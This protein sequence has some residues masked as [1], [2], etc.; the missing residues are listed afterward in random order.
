LSTPPFNGAKDYEKENA[1]AP[2][3]FR[4]EFFY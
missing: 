1:P 4:G 3:P 2:G